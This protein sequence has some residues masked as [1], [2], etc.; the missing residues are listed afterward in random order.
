[1]IALLRGFLAE[2][3]IPKWLTGVNA[4]LGDRRPISVLRKGCVADV[5]AATEAEKA[6]AHA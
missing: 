1:M 5:I 6:G 4:H 3:S 2:S